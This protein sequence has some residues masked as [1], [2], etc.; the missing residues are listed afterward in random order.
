MSPAKAAATPKNMAKAMTGRMSPLAS[1]SKG[2]VGM[3]FSSTS[4]KAGTVGALN[5]AT[6]ASFIPAA[7]FRILATIRP[8]VTA[9]AVVAR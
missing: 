9:M 7:G 2:L 6:G 8:M 1:E 3:R 4:F 5:P